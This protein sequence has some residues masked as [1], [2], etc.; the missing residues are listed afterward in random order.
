MAEVVG[1]VASG[2]SIGSL[3]VHIATSISKLKSFWDN[4]QEAP[5]DITSLIEEISLLHELLADI[6]DD[7]RRN[8]ISSLILDGTASSRCLEHCK[9][10]ADR[11]GELVDEISMDIQ[12]SSRTKRKWVAAKVV[13]KRDR[14]EKYRAKMERTIRLMTLAHQC[15]TKALVQLQPDIIVYKLKQLSNVPANNGSQLQ[16]MGTEPAEIPAVS[17][18]SYYFW[19]P[20]LSVEYEVA[21]IDQISTPG[22]IYN[23]GDQ[24]RQSRHR[25]RTRLRGPIL[26]LNRLWDIT[27]HS[28]EN[29]WQI[30]IRTYNIIP[31]KSLAFQYIFR[32]NIEGLRGLFEKREASPFDADASGATLLCHAA[33]YGTHQ[34]C[35]FLIEQGARVEPGLSNYPILGRVRQSFRSQDQVKTMRLLLEHGSN[36]P[37]PNILVYYFGN[38]EG[39]QFLTENLEVEY[40]EVPANQRACIAIEKTYHGALYTNLK[41]FRIALGCDSLN[42]S[43]LNTKSIH[44][45]TIL[46]AVCFAIGKLLSFEYSSIRLNY[47]DEA[48][49]FSFPRKENLPEEL[50]GWR[51]LLKEVV[52]L[53][54]DLHP[55]AFLPKRSPFL[56]LIAGLLE[57]NCRYGERLIQVATQMWL[58]DLNGSG[59]NLL[60]YGMTEM[61]LLEDGV[62]NRD[63]EC[64]ELGDRF[65]RLRRYLPWRF[66]GFTY[67]AN[68]EDWFV[69]GSEI[70][71]GLAG[72]FWKMVEKAERKL[73]RKAEREG[74]SQLPGAWVESSEEDDSEWDY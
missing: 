25:I 37:E 65:T 23:K 17:S 24:G 7:Q 14:L 70:C 74:E 73:E 12:S 1:L 72:E 49:C 13:L 48:V 58:V 8:P 53:G 21:K 10:A 38:L 9:R 3:T 34:I 5:E 54:A 28:A 64:E 47:C 63:L 44:G 26:I 15:Y 66:I 22:R 33:Y 50:Q 36:S 71:D 43:M 68:P 2:I 18:S 39:F 51:D 11:L 20:M 45:D 52:N 31:D 56:S 60:E 29:G 6:E 30:N 59:V 61:K 57:N 4:V 16:E 41:F 35:K 27:G 55:V 32:E 69:W 62:L 42:A 67:G 46:H 19:M 40:K